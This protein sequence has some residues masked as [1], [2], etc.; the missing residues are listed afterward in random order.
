LVKTLHYIYKDR[1]PNPNHPS[2]LFKSKISNHRLCDKKKKQEQGFPP[3]NP[4]L[5]LPA[6]TN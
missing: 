2:Y 4:S 5:F 3:T 6:I 1:N